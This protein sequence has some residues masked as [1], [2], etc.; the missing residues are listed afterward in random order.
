LM[1]LAKLTNADGDEMTYE[2]DGI[3]LTKQSDFK[4]QKT[5]YGYDQIGRVNQIKD[6]TGQVTNISHNDS[7]GH[8]IDITDRRTTHRVEVY[9][10][11]ERLKSVTYGGQPLVSYEYDG[12]NNRT[13]VIDGRQNRNVYSYDRANRLLS[14]DH[15][16]LQTERFGYDNVGNV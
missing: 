8:T 9:D 16:G 7:G 6:R 10:P 5:E 12:D 4:G 15:A 3:N 14:I 1:R 11:L 2:Y 13:A